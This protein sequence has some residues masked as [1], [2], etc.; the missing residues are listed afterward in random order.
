M[1]LDDYEVPYNDLNIGG[2]EYILS[3]KTWL[4]LTQSLEVVS[5]L[6]Q[7]P[8]KTTHFNTIRAQRISPHLPLSHTTTH[9][10]PQIVLTL[11][12]QQKPTS[13]P[14]GTVFTRWCIAFLI[15]FARIFAHVS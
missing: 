4:F 12:R 14:V 5:T 6:H 3:I 9:P 2:R 7:R 11:E 15:C 13:L 10:D 8:Y 1:A